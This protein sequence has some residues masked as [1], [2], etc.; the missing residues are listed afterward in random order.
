MFII[1]LV[2]GGVGILLLL[3]IVGMYNKLV[4]GRNRVKNAYAQIDVQLTRRYDLIPNLVETAK[5]YMK[6][7]RETLEAVTEARNQA[8]AAA[9]AVAGDP[10]NAGAMHSL[11]GAEGALAGSLGRLN[12]AVEAYPD[13]KA[14]ANM[15]QVQEE[16]TSTENKVSFARQG[17][18]D[19]VM[20][21]NVMREKFPDNI[22]ASMFSF[23][24]AAMF[25]IEDDS[26]KEA[27]KV[28]F[29]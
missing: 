4:V 18:N 7:E 27:P 1:F 11:I 17:Y 3:W 6:H 8:A 21:Y 28:D 10:T 29:S 5:G 25:E 2:L 15:L 26:M 16:L 20:H 9:K 14:S 12:V 13:L 22:I 23:N 19:S 24:E